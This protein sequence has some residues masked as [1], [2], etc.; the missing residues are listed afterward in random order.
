MK[1]FNK[2]LSL[3]LA[4]VMVMT[5]LPANAFAVVT[6]EKVTGDSLGSGV[7]NNLI[8]SAQG[9]V[10]DKWVTGNA[11]EIENPG[12]DLKKDPE[13]S[14]L[15]PLYDDN[16]MVRTIIVFEG[17][18]LLERGYDQ[19]DIVGNDSAIAGIEYALRKQ[20]DS[21]AQNIE[22]EIRTYSANR[23]ENATF[24][25]E[26]KYNYTV[27]LNGIATEIPYGALSMIRALDGVKDAYVV[28]QYTLPE[29]NMATTGF[30][31]A[32][33]TMNSSTGYIGT[34]QVWNDLGYT[35]KG[36]TI[37]VVDTGL[38]VDHPSFSVDPNAETA[39]LTQSKLEN[40]LSSLNAYELYAN[41]SAL[42][43]A[44][45]NVYHSVKVPF[46]FNYV[47]ENT[48]ITHDYD[49]QG[50][51]GTH[52]A[53][54]ATACRLTTTDVVGVA[55]DAQ[56]IVMKV[57]GQNGGAFGDDIMAALEDC[58]RMDI[59]VVNM[60]LGAPAGF[61]E[62]DVLMNEVFSRVRQ[63]DMML[64][65]AA[66]NSGSAAL[67]NEIG[68]NLN[69]TTDPDIGML[70]SPGTYHGATI[71]ASYENTHVMVTY[72]MVGDNK[73]AY[74]DVS[75]KFPF[76]KLEGEHAYV[77]VP[78]YGAASDYT[79]ID[80]RGKIAVVSRG[81]GD[82]LTFEVKARNAYNAGATALIVYN[83]SEGDLIS[84]MAGEILPNVFISKA[85]GE[86][87]K[88][89][90]GSDG[91]G[92]LNVLSAEHHSP[93]PNTYAGQMSD[94]SAWGV[95]PDLQ[96]AP[97][98]AAPGGMIYSAIDKGLYGIM[99][100]T[101]MASPHIAGMS[102]LVLQYLHEKHPELSD[103]EM[104][105]AVEA[106]VMS[107]ATPIVDPDGIL[108]S[109]RL[110]GAGAA[111]V[112][113]AIMSPVYL[114][115]LQRS[116]GE[117]TPKASIG[118]DADRTGVYTFS[119]QMNNFS[120]TDQ[121]Y[122]LDGSALTDQFVELFDEKTGKSLG[123][124]V[125]QSGRELSAS[126]EYVVDGVVLDYDF[127]GDGMTNRSDVQVVLD[128]VNGLGSVT[129][130]MDINSDGAVNTVD[131]QMLYE[132]PCGVT[133]EAG[134]S[135]TVEVTVTLSAADI[136]YIEAHYP[137]G[138]YVEGFI[139]AYAQSE[140]G[141][142]LSFPYLA[143][144]GD[145]TD[146]D[147]LDSGWYY[148]EEPVYE[149]YLH[150]IYTDLGQSVSGLG[151]NPYIDE[152]YNAEM[153]VLSPNGDTYYD[154]INEMY[155]SLLR[156]TE[157]LDFTWY[158]EDG[159]ELFYEYITYARK[160]YY[161]AAY[162]VNLPVIYTDAECAP[163]T[164][165]DENG[166]L[167]VED[168]EHLTFTIR[169]YLDDGELDAIEYDEKGRPD[170]NTDW[171]DEV[172]SMPIV[173][174]LQAP[175]MDISTIEYTVENGRTYVSFEVS[176]NY[177]I[178]A[179][180]PLTVGGAVL[181]YIPVQTK[182]AGVD[183]ETDTITIDITDYDDVIQLALG[184][185]GGNESFYE[186]VNPN[187]DG[188]NADR[189][190]A[191]SRLSTPE[192]QGQVYLTHD[193]NGWYSF[194]DASNLGMHT[195]AL[196]SEQP[197]VY[198]AEYIDGYVIGIQE[199][200]MTKDWQGYVSDIANEIFVMKA[201]QWDRAVIGGLKTTVYQ[202]PGVEGSYFTLNMIA[203]DM[204]FNYQTDK[205]YVLANALECRQFPEGV[206]N[207][208]L[209]VDYL[210]GE[211]TVL[212]I[213]E[214]AQ[215]ERFLALTLACDNQGVLYT[216]N[217]ENGHLY[218]ID[219]AG[220]KS[221]YGVD[222]EEITNPM[223][224]YLATDVDRD[225]KTDYY[226]AA[227]A[228]SMTVDHKTNKLYWAAYQGSTGI[229]YFFEVDKS[230]GAL[231]NE[232]ATKDNS[233]LVG[234]FKPYD[235]EDT[236][237]LIPDG[238]EPE[239]VRLNHSTLYMTVGQ[240]ATVQ[241]VVEPYYAEVENIEYVTDF[242]MV[243]NV[244][245]KYGVVEAIGEGFGIV[246]AWYDTPGGDSGYVS[247]EVYVSNVGGTMFA[248]SGDSWL[249]MD[250]SKPTEARTVT[251]AM[252]FEEGEEVKA[253]AYYGGA[254]YVAT[255]SESYTYDS[256]YA[257]KLYKLDPNTLQGV[258]IG[259]YEGIT[260]ALAFN[261]A[262]G[263]MY[264]LVKTE[265][266]DFGEESGDGYE[267]D[268]GE[269][270]DYGDGE[271]PGYGGGEAGDFNYIVTYELVTVN[272]LTA[273]TNV[274]DDL[275]TFFPYNWNE[276][277]EC[278][279]SGA[280]AID[281]EGNF[282]V[283]GTDVDYEN[284]LVRF[285]LTDG[286]I[287]EENAVIAWGLF[288]EI[289][290]ESGEA[291]V[292]SER[293]G[294]L[295]RAGLNDNY[296][297]CLKFLDL[298]E[299]EEC[300]ITEIDLGPVRGSSY[301]GV[302]ALVMP[303]DREPT[304][305]GDIEVTGLTLQDSY[306]VAQG[307]SI[308]VVPSITPWNATAELEYA[309]TAG[310]EYAAVDEKGNV[311][312]IAVGTAVLTVSVVGTDISATAVIEVTENPGYLYGFFQADLAQRIPLNMWGRIPVA[313]SADSTYLSDEFTFTVYAAEYY[314]G[315]VYAF[316]QSDLDGLYYSLR[317]NP[318]NFYYQ[319]LSRQ[320]LMV[321]DMAFD[322]TTGTMYVTAYDESVIGGIYQM[323]LTTGAL[324]FICDMQMPVVGIAVDDEG[325]LF[326]ASSYGDLVYGDADTI[327][328]LAVEYATID[329]PYS[330]YLQSMT[331]DYNNDTIYMAC[332]GKL[333]R[334]D[335]TYSE[336]DGWYEC[337][338]VLVGTVDVNS[339]EMETTGCV[340]SGLFSIP[341]V[342][343]DE[344]TTVEP[345]GVAI[346]E[347]STVAVDETVSLSAVVL[348]V[349]VHAMD[350]SLIWESDDESIATV[351][352]FGNV[353]GVSE[354]EVAIYVYNADDTIFG[355]CTVYVTA[356]ARKFYAYDEINR[357]WKS[358]D[359]KT[360]EQLNFWPDEAGLSPIVAATY[361]AELDTLY[362]Y[363]ADGYFY[364][365][366]TTD[367]SR[368]KLGD[369]I[370]GLSVTLDANDDANGVYTVESNYEVVDLTYG[371]TEDRMGRVSVTMYG[372]AIAY[373]ISEWLDSFSYVVFEIDMETGEIWTE[374][375]SDELVDG[376]MSLR[377]TNLYYANNALYIVNGYITGM[378]TKID[379][380]DGNSVT[381]QNIF[382]DYWGD[383]NGSRS[384][385]RDP[386]T[387]EVYALRDLVTQYYDDLYSEAVLVKVGL[388]TAYAEQMF[389]LG[390]G[391]RLTGLF[392]K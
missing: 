199:G 54:T 345:A 251:D 239:N 156:N 268:E 198:A 137:N 143:Y 361:V 246:G 154:S 224:R 392:I 106:L 171:A 215:G 111:D 3:L 358:F 355:M 188:A 119:F 315:T 326:A 256:G 281:Y 17:E 173:I 365:I 212:G 364:I 389:S 314:D 77:M 129:D 127:N 182:V 293:N 301:S 147:V 165:L 185:Y 311:T 282:Y 346:P 10:S 70:T 382:A 163:F 278:I 265:I 366:D 55:P 99:S 343:I 356:E 286:A 96:L 24:K 218:T 186:L 220:A 342:E 369:G 160:S 166:D 309:I 329:V 88:A 324:T 197:D 231:S 221:A 117:L 236:A 11:T 31:T 289:S 383:F 193:L 232:V 204:A 330:A 333:Y 104:H 195:S 209:E 159:S 183:G 300:W 74:N 288:G 303:I 138:I 52:V 4:V 167:M 53:G 380:Y 162:G 270:P 56:L 128:A 32:E 84:M 58:I 347:K 257:T 360:G 170:P 302:R 321:R 363:D 368:E 67:M 202:W 336:E 153:N 112:Y 287:E 200:N 201:G 65:V 34:Q 21:M 341:M 29:D 176:D 98:V 317:I 305:P 155:I 234:L 59:D 276:G 142:D 320:S 38:D 131:A 109:P 120:N 260:T 291:M 319:V 152:A 269:D 79:N 180:I 387:G 376:E 373:N 61:T 344:P 235:T 126:I 304:L 139:R 13:V 206:E 35:G 93:I 23:G 47:D 294:G 371:L 140:G 285:T 83:H 66:G 12:V 39:A 249:L 118:D 27:A 362:A 316:G 266:W 114:T 322:Y 172:V 334:F 378:I 130:T 381:G 14:T 241:V 108:Y 332:E 19:D 97:D 82:L 250:V 44:V 103:E 7:I 41:S 258:L 6:G 338:T 213:I 148:E 18:S 298:S 385:I 349:S 203:L 43:L 272:P 290:E 225:G 374:I 85:D 192:Y 116:T 226:P 48:E 271:M 223:N 312:G 390:N 359:S 386:I 295:I 211:F 279:C 102:A 245:Q 145:W 168:L 45:E 178:A 149:R 144:Y 110:Q 238:A 92:T 113:D 60:S 25:L 90:A 105:I 335:L 354:G 64:A 384:I 175:K 124:F 339:G 313:D 379:L 5:M 284:V 151:L 252:E 219:V 328:E 75:E 370:N 71:V 244:S 306:T 158:G 121:S 28:T 352:Q 222:V 150:V 327:A 261:Y 16:E 264:G 2:I 275:D 388:G 86:I 91:E 253:A 22:S 122:Y 259:E 351:D 81:G 68:T 229:S 242:G 184:D 9:S 69:Y 73:V 30:G 72:F 280:L 194:T 36:M 181:E 187:S 115:S 174:D 283:S 177:D 134:E 308:T 1:K 216:V 263:N 100:G 207:L 63:S 157:L 87:L 340:V 141:V 372:V 318:T 62:E 42:P 297:N 267:F 274:V 377:P 40:V 214:A 299:I 262:D 107:T 169:A 255:V 190:Y 50:D 292:W 95:T 227:Y 135:V 78:G 233:E 189:F 33:P 323:D 357:G 228:Q 307:E 243:L 37:A 325:T 123:E 49:D 80:V 277:Y 205:L 337:E 391:L 375:V 331:Y 146:P 196:Q 26:V 273:E 51:H 136:A 240:T 46:G 247:C 210:T 133:V 191:Y 230:T 248:F 310:S 125:G 101:S 367:F 296:D 217:Y 76:A 161:W 15:T 20:Q 353:T 164:A 208:L 94:F 348:P 89:A 237:N 57:F 350:R 132:I 8:D 179:V 254:I